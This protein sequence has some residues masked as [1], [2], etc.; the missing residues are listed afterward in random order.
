MNE[1]N[2]MRHAGIAR[3]LTGLV[4]MLIVLALVVNGTGLMAPDRSSSL[5]AVQ[6]IAT[7]PML[8]Y[9]AAI[10][11]IRQ[12]FFALSKGR[13][14]EQVVARLLMRMGTLLF[15]GGLL[16]VFAEPLLT[17]MVLQRPWPVANFDIAAITLGTVGLLLFLL[18]RPLQHAA[19]MRTELDE[20][21]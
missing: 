6:A 15:V 10:W 4:V 2:Y 21:M 8:C 5:R 12:A 18:A 20:F 13:A 11:T 7:L 3:H 14:V 9:L 17:R 1:G 19:E 16:R